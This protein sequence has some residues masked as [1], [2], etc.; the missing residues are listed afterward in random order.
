MQTERQTDTDDFSL[1][2]I[3]G[4]ELLLGIFSC[5]SFVSLRAPHTGKV[6]GHVPL[7]DIWLRRL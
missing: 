7:L 1:I 4:S 6:E 2:T 3:L 5:S